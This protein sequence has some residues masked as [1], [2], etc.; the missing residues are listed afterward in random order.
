MCFLHISGQQY[1][2][3][4]NYLIYIYLKPIIFIFICKDIDNKYNYITVSWMQMHYIKFI[5]IF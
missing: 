3:N 1:L 2:L 4:I 5:F